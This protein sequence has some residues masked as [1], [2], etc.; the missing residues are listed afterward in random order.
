[1]LTPLYASTKIINQIFKSISSH[2]L[3]MLGNVS[4][5]ISKIF[6]YY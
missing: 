1:M 5:N 6:S 2:V 3:Y 4:Q